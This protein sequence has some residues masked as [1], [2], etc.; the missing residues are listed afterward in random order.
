MTRD[1]TKKLLLA[2][3]LTYSNFKT[4]D[5]GAVIDVWHSILRVEDAQEIQ[6]AF[7]TFARTDMSGFAPTP[8][9][10]CQMVANRKADE[11]TDGEVITMLTM[12]SR[13]ANYGFEEEFN[14]LP[15]LLQKAVGSPTVIRNWGLM[16]SEELGYTFNQLARTYHRLVEEHK[17]EQ[18][19][20]KI[21]AVQNSQIGVDE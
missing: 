1:D 6:D 3:S 18:E 8:G 5:L 12:A 11:M 2:I 10:L 7:V 15:P 13:N 19:F 21:G 20:I 4:V 14:K 16:E 9:I 17:T